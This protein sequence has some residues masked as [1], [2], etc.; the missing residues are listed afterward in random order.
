[1]ATFV[2]ITTPCHL[3]L[4]TQDISVNRKDLRAPTLAEPTRLYQWSG[5]PAALHLDNQLHLYNN[6]LALGT[7]KIKTLAVPFMDAKITL[8]F[9][10]LYLRRSPKK[11]F[12]LLPINK[13]TKK[14]IRSSKYV[15]IQ[16]KRMFWCWI[17]KHSTKIKWQNISLL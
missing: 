15:C 13:E 3:I 6:I 9:V 8:N 5:P 12:G 7:P 2:I 4:T 11:V 1:M 14:I 10:S 17:K 16:K